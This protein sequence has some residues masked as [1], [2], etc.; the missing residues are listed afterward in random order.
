MAKVLIVEDSQSQAMII[1]EIVKSAGHEPT[2]APNLQK[3][4][5][6]VLKSA[7]P[8]VVLLDLILLGPDGKTI[9]D[10]FQFC[11]EIKKL[12]NNTVGVVIVSSRVDEES[13]QWAELQGAD[14]MLQKPFVVED[15]IEVMDEVL[16]KFKKR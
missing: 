6:P 10:G 14:A 12:S 8:D 9:G 11:K 15:L 13:A 16:Q 4:I 7:N 3:G 5:A 2:V 1:S